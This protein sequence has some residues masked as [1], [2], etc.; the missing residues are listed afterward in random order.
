VSP[1]RTPGKAADENQ[2]DIID[3]RRKAQSELVVDAKIILS[4]AK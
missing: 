1:I 3:V 2:D 4:T